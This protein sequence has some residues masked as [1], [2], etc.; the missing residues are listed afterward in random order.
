MVEQVSVPPVCQFHCRADE[1]YNSSLDSCIEGIQNFSVTKRQSLEGTHFAT[2]SFVKREVNSP[3]PGASSSQDARGNFAVQPAAN[4]GTL[5]LKKNT[6][7]IVSAAAP[8]LSA[9]RPRVPPST[10]VAVAMPVRAAA[11]LPTPDPSPTPGLVA[12]QASA[13][14]NEPTRA[15]QLVVKL[16]PTPSA[17][18]LPP[19]KNEL[20]SRFVDVKGSLDDM[21]ARLS[22]A[23]SSVTSGPAIK[24]S[25]I[26]PDG[27]IFSFEDRVDD[28][29]DAASVSSRTTII[30]QSQD[31]KDRSALAL[32]ATEPPS[33]TL[34]Q[35]LP[36]GMQAPSTSSLEDESQN[37][38]EATYLRKAAAYLDTLPTRPGDTAHS[39]KAA[40][41]KLRT[42]YVPNLH[43]NQP[44]EVDKMRARIAFAVTS[45]AKKN[46]KASPQPLTT[47]MVKKI[48]RHCDG[49]F[50]RLCAALA[51]EGH[52]TLRDLKHVTDLCQSVL[53]VLPKADD[54]LPAG[55]S[56]KASTVTNST[57]LATPAAHSQETHLEL[58]SEKN[59]DTAADKKEQGDPLVG[60]K[61]WPTQEKREHGAIYRACILKGVGG[62][63]S[64][65]QLQAL[66]W[67]GR[68]ESIQMPEPGSEHA[69][70]KFLTPEACQAYL[71]ATENGIEV[72][73]AEKKTIVFVDKQ[74]GPNSI[75]DVIQ[76]CTESDASRCVR[77]TGADDDWSEGAL[78]KLAH[79][80]QSTPRDIDCIRQ[81]KTAQGHHYIEFRFANIYHAL[82]FRR[83]LMDD[84]EWEHCS[85]GY[86]KD[87]CELARGVHY[88]DADEEGGGF[89]AWT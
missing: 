10:S 54:G 82:N 24:L 6:V 76:N 61:A 81:G 27:S 22:G 68:L 88:K 71:D 73:G 56:S 77:A 62:V 7:K 4:V 38:R 16:V 12:P 85:I 30:S 36:A 84:E 47:D 3:S 26:G 33:A 87:P 79:G 39:V 14:E 89:L 74:Q 21:F 46:I 67:G 42:V 51:K 59:G 35:T 78:F 29:T 53:E 57:S 50:L 5:K 72:Q 75:N 64:L 44:D 58:T 31:S 25:P 40:A 70:V 69:F 20:P 15:P 55:T 1:L 49:D 11:P 2:T 37:E 43:D 18:A 86:A 66:V 52:I 28:A 63:K 17:A 83:H 32:R 48:L 41:E 65:H 80:K 9:P 13:K 34:N 8:A 60:M 45:A 23:A 19:S